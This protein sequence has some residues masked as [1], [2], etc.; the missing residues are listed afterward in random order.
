[1][2]AQP[3]YSSGHK[4]TTAP[5]PKDLIIDKQR[6]THLPTQHVRAATACASTANWWWCPKTKSNKPAK[7]WGY[8]LTRTCWAPH[9]Y[10]NS[11]AATA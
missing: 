2:Q 11:T 5:K 10:W 1:M 4:A 6:I 8:G 9:G 7:N 3:P